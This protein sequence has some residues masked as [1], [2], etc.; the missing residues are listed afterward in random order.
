MAVELDIIDDYINV[1]PVLNDISTASQGAISLWIK[2]PPDDNGQHVCFSISN[3]AGATRSEI[4]IVVDWRNSTGSFPGNSFLV[5]LNDSGATAWEFNAGAG[6]LNPFAREWVNLVLAHNG[7]TP[8]LY[9]N[10][11][12]ISINFT[13]STDKTK[14]F[15]DILS[16]GGTLA[17]VATIGAIRLNGS[18]FGHYG[19]QITET[20]IYDTN[21]SLSDIANLYSFVKHSPI[22][23][24]AQAYFPMDDLADGEDLNG[25]NFLNMSVNGNNGTGVDSGGSGGQGRAEEVLSYPGNPIYVMP[26]LAVAAGGLSRYHDLTGLGGQGDMTRNPLG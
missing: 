26:G 8:I 17:D 6:F 22:N 4:T 13:D 12:L 7:T 1:S 23:V 9:V 24:N 19:D 2:I 20:S 18:D 25:K 3:N 14:W 16:G 21:P 5:F 11:S 15:A 10:N